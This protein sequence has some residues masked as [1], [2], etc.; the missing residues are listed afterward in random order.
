MP[1]SG[2]WG[3]TSMVAI[4]THAVYQNLSF[5]RRHLLAGLEIH[6]GSDSH[7]I[8]RETSYIPL[9]GRPQ[10]S[11]MR[12]SSVYWILLARSTI[13]LWH[14]I[15][16]PSKLR[17]FRGLLYFGEPLNQKSPIHW[18]TN[19]ARRPIEMRKMLDASTAIFNRRP[20]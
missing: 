9:P 18:M 5:H 15:Q 14:R 2:L 17:D 7:R 6:A 11:S 4:A 1:L 19:F 16:E 10:P 8:V 3:S 13:S 20:K 12:R